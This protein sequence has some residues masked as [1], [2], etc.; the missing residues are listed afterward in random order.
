MRFRIHRS[1]GRTGAYSQTDP[2]RAEV[3]ARRLA[4][5][6]M[7]RAGPIVIGTQN[8]FTILN[9]DEIC[10]IEVT[11]DH[12]FSI[13]RSASIERVVQIPGRAEY[14]ALLATQWPRWRRQFGKP[15]SG[16]LLEALIELSLTSGESVYLR[17]IGVDS[18]V[19][20]ATEIFGAPSIGAEIEAGG[21][22]Y[23]NPKCVVRAR[24]YHS[25]EHVQFP[26]GIWVAEAD[27]I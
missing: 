13:P 16:T 26:D 4:P 5:D 14:E 8:P 17:V 3:L 18:E 20:L 27:D 19:D 10:W 23:V 1:D 22:L 11:G 2:R 9:P 24:V 21:V 12:S 7:F 25:K 6:R 15:A